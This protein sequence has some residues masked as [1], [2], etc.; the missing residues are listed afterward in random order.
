MRLFF[1]LPLP[2]DTR[3]L[4]AEYVERQ[5]RLHPGLRWIDPGGAHITLRFLGAVDP[6]EPLELLRNVVPDPPVD[7][8]FRLDT[9]GTFPRGSKLPGVY[10]LG[11]SFPP[12]AAG[13]ADRL[14]VLR[15]DA[16]R[17]GQTGLF[18]PHLTVARRGRQEGFAKLPPPG[19][20]EGSFEEIVLYDSR[21]TPSGPVYERVGSAPLPSP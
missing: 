4:L 3:A 15:D 16:G 2:A 11:G 7:R 10:W 9:C 18:L 19:P 1:A 20:W 14:A 21:L 17:T 13:A 5:R 6:S 8:S 12:W